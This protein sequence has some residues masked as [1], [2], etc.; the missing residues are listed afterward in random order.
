M[1]RSA[2]N[3][4]IKYHADQ[5]YG[6]FP[7]SRHLDSVAKIVEPWGEQAVQVAYLHD[8]VEDTDATIAEIEDHFGKFVADCVQILTDEPGADR[9]ERKKR[10]NHK[11][12]LVQPDLFIALVVKAADRLSNLTACVNQNHTEKLAMYVAEH[13][14]FRQSAYRAGLCESLWR[15]MDELLQSCLT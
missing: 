14:Q 4:A 9:A 8:V 13:E 11:L 3:F 10:T 6:V 5:K 2:R 1:I 7:Y 12:S 15:E